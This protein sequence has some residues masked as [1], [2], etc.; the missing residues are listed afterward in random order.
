MSSCGKIVK[1]I[2]YGD[3]NYTDYDSNQVKKVYV[4]QSKT[5]DPL[6]SYENMGE[7]SDGV[8]D[9][10][11]I[12]GTVIQWNNEL[13]YVYAGRP[14]TDPAELSLYIAHM[15]N[16]YTLDSARAM[17][18]QPEYSWEKKSGKINEG[19]QVLIK[20]GKLHIIYSANQA[21]S[22]NY[23]LGMLTYKGS[24]SLLSKNSWVKSSQPVFEGANGVYSPGHA[25]F[26]TSPDGKEDWIVYHVY[27]DNK[28]KTRQNWHREVRIQKFTWNGITPVFGKP[29]ATGA[30]QNVP[31]GSTP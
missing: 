10:H 4:L 12:D 13:Y 31:S 26:T 17:I 7:V 3:Q 6:G 22:L 24:G 16:P 14:G 2:L 30:W 23:C 27:P 28:I 21:S 8:H 15:K 25:S 1:T 11:G 19:P 20:N 29:L 5:S 9:Y 18:A